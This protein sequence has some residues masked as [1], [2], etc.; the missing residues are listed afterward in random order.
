MRG[1][2]ICQYLT[3]EG[4]VCRRVCNRQEG[5]K[6]H[7]K[8]H[9]QSP[10]KQCG[11]PTASMHRMCNL[12]VDKHHSK[13]YYHRKKLNALEKSALGESALGKFN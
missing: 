10:C 6:I 5:C 3:N 13:T 11:K 12:H 9:Q 4:S 1:E 2:F 7:W 8:R